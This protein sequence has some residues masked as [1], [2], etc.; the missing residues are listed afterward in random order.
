MISNIVSAHYLLPDARDVF[1]HLSGDGKP[2]VV[3]R[4]RILLQLDSRCFVEIRVSAV[5][6]ERGQGE[7]C[8][9]KQARICRDRQRGV[10]E[11]ELQEEEEEE[12]ALRS[13][14][15]Q[16]RREGMVGVLVSGWVDLLIA[17][18]SVS[19]CSLSNFRVIYIGYHL[20]RK[21]HNPLF[22][23]SNHYDLTGKKTP[24][25]S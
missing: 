20:E 2:L 18:S 15:S 16:C 4:E 1:P 25:F 12:A 17:L 14:Y 9:Q 6:S 3:W 19:L 21:F 13:R 10:C 22:V 11:R 24:S 8:E 23:I 7:Q 5:E